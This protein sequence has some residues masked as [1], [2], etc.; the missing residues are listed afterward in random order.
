VRK[1]VDSELGFVADGPC[2]K[3][4]AKAPQNQLLTE[5]MGSPYLKNIIKLYC[6]FLFI[7]ARKVVGCAVAVQ[8]DQGYPVL[9]S[10]GKSST[11]EKQIAA[12]CCR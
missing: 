8:I 3:F 9:P 2:G 1:V 4:E 10:P 11:P 7:S 12:W 5:E 6:T